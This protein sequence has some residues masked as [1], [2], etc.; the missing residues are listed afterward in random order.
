[1]ATIHAITGRFDAVGC[2]EGVELKGMFTDRQL[3]LIVGESASDVWTRAGRS[4][5]EAGT[6]P[7]GFEPNLYL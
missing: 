1:V 3:F 5:E 4:G 7:D 2:C 6:Q